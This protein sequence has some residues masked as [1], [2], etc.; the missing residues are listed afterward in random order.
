MKNMQRTVIFIAVLV[1]TAFGI[2]SIWSNVSVKPQPITLEVRLGDGV[3][4]YHR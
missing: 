3:S 1:A 4:G 2:Y